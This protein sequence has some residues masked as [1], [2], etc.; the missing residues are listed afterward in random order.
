MANT[1]SRRD[2]TNDPN[3]RLA[4]QVGEARPWR[5]PAANVLGTPEELGYRVGGLV[6]HGFTI[7][8]RLPTK[9][10]QLT[11]DGPGGNAN[12]KLPRRYRGGSKFGDSHAYSGGF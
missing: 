7:P 5:A 6:Q 2:Q 10:R 11:Q 9:F 1:N 4:N 8:D 3:E 12:R